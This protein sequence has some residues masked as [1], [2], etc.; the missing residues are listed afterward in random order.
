MHL[1]LTRLDEVTFVLKGKQT[2]PTK[3]R[4]VLN[5][6]LCTICSFLRVTQLLGQRGT[7]AWHPP[8]ARAPEHAHRRPELPLTSGAQ[9]T[10]R[11]ASSL[12]PAGVWPLSTS[13]CLTSPQTRNVRLP[14]P[15]PA[16]SLGLCLD[17]RAPCEVL[18]NLC[19]DG[20]ALV[21]LLGVP[22]RCQSGGHPR[23]EAQPGPGCNHRG[24][25]DI[26]AVPSAPKQTGLKQT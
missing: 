6:C 25:G 8:G 19:R 21:W 1:F 17:N 16:L 13:L 2:W 11:Q 26:L 20:E 7:G 4:T 9:A 12:A 5:R 18:Q 24:G 14:P 23:R 15:K 10:E 22:C 3:H